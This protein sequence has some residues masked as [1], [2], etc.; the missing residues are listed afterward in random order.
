MTRSGP[1]S[2]DD[3]LDRIIARATG[4][5]PP[6][7]WRLLCSRALKPLACCRDRGHADA[8]G[9]G[10]EFQG[11]LDGELTAQP[12]RGVV[13]PQPFRVADRRLGDVLAGDGGNGLASGRLHAWCRR[14]PREAGISCLLNMFRSFLGVRAPDEALEETPAA[15]L[16]Y[17]GRFCFQAALGPRVIL[18]SMAD[19]PALAGDHFPAVAGGVADRPV[20]A[21]LEV[22]GIGGFLGH[23]EMTQGRRGSRPHRR[24][25]RRRGDRLLHHVSWLVSIAR[26][27]WLSRDGHKTLGMVLH[28]SQIPGSQID[29]E[30][31]PGIFREYF[32]ARSCAVG[33]HGRLK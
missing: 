24:A 11:W 8:E 7:A 29:R 16:G 32:I 5:L 10:G 14:Q 25:G 19:E 2:G 4:T 9:L 27:P 33:P 31:R 1:T 30:F 12:A 22:I 6:L 21:P 26:A 20:A 3:A 17:R 23:A 28:Y 15:G 13:S 18:S